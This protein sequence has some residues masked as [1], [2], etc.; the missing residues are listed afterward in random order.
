MVNTQ[1]TTNQV[2]W[3]GMMGGGSSNTT[4][5]QQD[6]NTTQS[7]AV[8]PNNTNAEVINMTYTDA[9]LTPSIVNITVWKSY[10]IVIQ[11]EINVYGCMSTIGI[12]GLDDTMQ[13]IK[14]WSTIT[15]NI[16]PTRAGE[17]EFLCA[18]WVPHNAKIIVQ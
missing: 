17:Y 16:K 10:T 8:V 7:N 15:F 2:W 14:K 9:G 3:C 1:N 11:P 4:T 5:Q 13:L 18:M 6:T 12:P